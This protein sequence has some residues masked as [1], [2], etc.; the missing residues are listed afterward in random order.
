LKAVLRGI[1]GLG[2]ASAALIL[3]A[4]FGGALHPMFDSVAVFRGVV[5]FGGLLVAFLLWMAGGSLRATGLAISVPLAAFVSLVPHWAGRA[6]F[7]VTLTLYQ[8]NLARLNT[9]MRPLLADIRRTDPDIITLQEV[10]WANKYLLDDL[11]TDYPHQIVCLFHRWVGDVAVLSRFPVSE[12]EGLCPG[13]AGVAILPI[14]TPAGTVTAV[15]VH[16]HWPWPHGQPEQAQSL[17]RHLAT[18][19]GMMVL[20]GDFNMVRWSTTLRQIARAGRIA[21]VGASAVTYPL[22]KDAGL[23]IDHVLATGGQ[24]TTEYRRLYG[25]DHRGIL[26]RINLSALDQ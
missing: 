21:P 25:S 6:Q 26:A 2:A 13:P 12:A 10:T 3:V 22:L 23:S 5:S 7:P 4:G 17:E 20:G 11:R 16:F 14:E 8:K 9:E 15:S 18:L 1:F 19:D 24:G